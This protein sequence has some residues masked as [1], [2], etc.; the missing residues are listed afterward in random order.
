[1]QNTVCR[2]NTFSRWNPGF[3]NKENLV[4]TFP[5]ILTWHIFFILATD[6]S[7]IEKPVFLLKNTVFGYLRIILHLHMAVSNVACL[8]NNYNGN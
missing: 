7:F 8:V 3:R 1:M 2:C 6:R 4:A 5:E